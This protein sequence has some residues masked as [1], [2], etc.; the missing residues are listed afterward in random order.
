[1]SLLLQ[2]HAGAGKVQERGPEL[3]DQASQ[4][5]QRGV[6]QATQ[7]AQQGIGKA[8]GERCRWLCGSGLPRCCV[9]VRQ[10]MSAALQLSLMF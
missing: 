4:Q 1:M 2:V 10:R 7:G 8:Q 3:G 5:T 6:G 9:M